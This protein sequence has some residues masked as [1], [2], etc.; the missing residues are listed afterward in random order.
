MKFLYSGE[1]QISLEVNVYVCVY[2]YPQLDIVSAFQS[3]GEKMY[4]RITEDERKEIV[5]NA[6]PGACMHT[7]TYKS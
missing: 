4:D 3:Y 2:I 1:I 7:R 6:C 5:Q